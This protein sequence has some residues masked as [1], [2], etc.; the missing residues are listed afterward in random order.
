MRS[1]LDAAIDADADSFTNA[2]ARLGYVRDL[3]KVD[4]ELLLAQA[5]ALGDWYLQD[6]ELTIDPDYVAAVIASL[7]DPRAMEGSLRLV[8]Q[9]KVPPQEIWLRRV[10]VSVLA[11]LGQL[12]ARR[13]WHRIM[14]DIL[15]EEPAGE[16]G[17]LDAEFWAQ[18]RWSRSPSGR[19]G[20]SAP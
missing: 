10:E 17:R 11:V 8:R 1:A 5:L 4:R 15:G 13:N 19:S 16:L 2:A 20:S 6:R 18:R 14:L 12:R 7:I 9:L 3:D